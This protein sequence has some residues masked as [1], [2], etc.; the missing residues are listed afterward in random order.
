M[1]SQEIISAAWAF[2]VFVAFHAGWTVS[3]FFA[4]K[5]IKRL[6]DKVT[7][8]RQARYEKESEIIID[9]R[10]KYTNL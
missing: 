2:L 5:K 10:R 1:N 7:E 8:E 4:N 6:E 3:C 9:L